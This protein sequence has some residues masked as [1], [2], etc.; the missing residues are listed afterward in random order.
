MAEFKRAEAKPVP[1]NWQELGKAYALE[2][3]AYMKSEEYQNLDDPRKDKLV[4]RT[5]N[6]TGHLQ[7]AA[8]YIVPT[9]AEIHSYF[10]T[11]LATPEVAKLKFDSAIDEM[12]DWGGINGRGYVRVFAMQNFVEWWLRTYT[13][14]PI[15]TIKN[16]YNTLDFITCEPL[17]RRLNG[18]DIQESYRIIFKNRQHHDDLAIKRLKLFG[19]A[20]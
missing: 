14:Y 7:P 8:V 15:F 5:E 16:V 13:D 19:G 11:V 2:R 10:E 17:V 4:G 3:E 18:G 9:D 12:D 20:S 6:R 1:D